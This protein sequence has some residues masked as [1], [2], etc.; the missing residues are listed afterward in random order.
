QRI[1]ATDADRDLRVGIDGVMGGYLL[2]SGADGLAELEQ[3]YLADPQ[4]SQDNV[5]AVTSA[6]RFMWE[7]GEGKISPDRLRQS[8]RLALQHEETLE[9]AIV[10]LAR[11]QDWAVTP[12]IVALYPDAYR[13]LQ[14]RIVGFL[15]VAS[16]TQEQNLTDDERAGVELARQ[17][18]AKNEQRSAKRSGG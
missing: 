8:M 18:L 13:G 10:D 4:A 12:Q 2:L 3:A 17:T 14:R 6:L 15:T 9:I 11:W 1:F 5:N 7:Y 16:E